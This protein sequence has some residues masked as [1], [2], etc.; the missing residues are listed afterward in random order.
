[1]GAVGTFDVN[2]N[3]P[4]AKALLDCTN[5]ISRRLGRDVKD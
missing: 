1:M 5:A 2:W 3:S 4:I